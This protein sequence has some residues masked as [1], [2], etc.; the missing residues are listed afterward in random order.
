VTDV[1]AGGIFAVL[2]EFDR[3][4]VIGALMKAGDVAF[5]SAPGDEIEALKLRQVL[6]VEI[7]IGWDH[8]AAIPFGRVGSE[9]GSP[10]G[11][12]F[13]MGLDSTLVRN[14]KGEA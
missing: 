6:R 13:G 8:G 3:E 5:D 7:G 12:V 9:C 11:C 14:R 10:V 2:G 4:T 1:V